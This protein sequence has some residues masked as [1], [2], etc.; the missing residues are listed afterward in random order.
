MTPEA[1]VGDGTF[2]GTHSP[3]CRT[4]NTLTRKKDSCCGSALRTLIEVSVY[5]LKCAP[6]LRTQRAEFITGL[7]QNGGEVRQRGGDSR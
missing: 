5:S 1:D 6:N 7:D 3:P 4:A 2:S